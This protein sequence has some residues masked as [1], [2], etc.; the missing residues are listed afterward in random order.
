MKPDSDSIAFTL[1]VT[2]WLNIHGSLSEVG[3]KTI[4]ALY[5]RWKT[6]FLPRL[7]LPHKGQCVDM[8]MKCKRCEVEEYFEN[9]AAIDS[10]IKGHNNS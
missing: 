1:F 6:E 8:A 9:A 4:E 5:E 2:S 10:V 7:D 3:E